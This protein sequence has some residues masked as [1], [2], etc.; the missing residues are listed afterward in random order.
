MEE[1]ST[2][3]AVRAAIRRGEWRRP[4]AGL[5]PGYTQANLLVLPRDLAYD[6]L[7]V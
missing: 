2:P 6:F 4:T 5:A 1:L 3:T 7:L